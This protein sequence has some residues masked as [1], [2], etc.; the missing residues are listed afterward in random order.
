[1]PGRTCRV[2][3]TLR[4]FDLDRR[5]QIGPRV[6]PSS[7]DIGGFLLRTRHYGRGERADNEGN[8]STFGKGLP[9]SWTRSAQGPMLL[10]RSALPCPSAPFRSAFD[11]KR[12]AL[13]GPPGRTLTD[14][15]SRRHP[16]A[17]AAR[18]VSGNRI[19]R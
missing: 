5:D 17:D 14:L 8:P 7:V 2:S 13:A 18:V 11:P 16:G 10:P 15:T 19:V 12:R 6:S 3:G 1:R 4:S 9:N